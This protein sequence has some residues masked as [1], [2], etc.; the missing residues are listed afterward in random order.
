[1]GEFSK[2]AQSAE[3]DFK[4]TLCLPQTD[5]PLRADAAQNDPRMLLRWENEG[6]CETVMQQNAGALRFILHDGPPYANGH[7]HLGH[8]YN[9]VLKDIITKSYRMQGYHVPITPGWDC[10][11]LPIEQKVTSENPRLTGAALKKECRTY[12]LR[13]VETQKEEFKKLGVCMDWDNPYITMNPEYE[14]SILSAFASLV[15]QGFV[16]RKNKTI[17][18]CPT[19]A[20]A[21]AAAEIEYADRKDPSIFVLFPVAQE[22]DIPA[23]V[24][25]WTTTPWT[26]PLNQAVMVR[27][28]AMYV[29]VLVQGK[30][31]I[32]G[33][34]RFASVLDVE[35]FEQ[36]VVQEE[37]LGSSLVGMLLQHPL[38]E[39][40]V[41]VIGDMNVGVNEGSACVHCAPGC[42]PI[43][44]EV[45]IKQGL[46]IYSPISADGKYS[47]E[48][49]PREL[50]G[51]SVED[52]QI[53]VLRALKER[54]YLLRSGSVR[55][56]Y[57]HCWRCHNGLIFRATPQWFCSLQ[58][59][60]VKNRALTSIQQLSFFPEQGRAFL[61]ATVENRWEWCLSRQRNWGVPIPALIHK[62]NNTYWT[63]PELI[64]Y[65]A[66]E[67]A[68]AGIEFWDTVSLEA[69][70]QVGVLPAD[71]VLDEYRKETDILDV[72][73]DSGVS[74]YAVLQKQGNFPADLYLEGIDQHRGW[75]QSSLLTSII[76]H[77]A[78][79][80]KSI[81]THG[82]TVDGQGRK[83]S[84][85]LGNV[86][87]PDE[88][89]A[90][91]GTDG[92]RLWVASIGNEGDAVLS[93]TLIQNVI[94]VYRKIRNTSR[95]LLQN[96]YDY[97][98]KQDAV[99]L[100]K[101]SLID[102]YALFTLLEFQNN[103][104]DAYKRFD[105]TEVFRLV[106]EYCSS[107]VS[108]FYADITKDR[109]Y[110]DAAKGVSRRSAQTVIW[111]ILDTLTRLI[112]PICSLMAES[113]AD[114]YQGAGHASIHL[115]SFANLTDIQALFAQKNIEQ[116]RADWALLREIRSA[117]LKLIEEQ[118]AAG[119]IKHPLEVALYID[120][121]QFPKI[122]LLGN[123]QDVVQRLFQEL[124]VASQVVFEQSGDYV[125][126]PVAGFSARVEHATGSKCPRC[127]QWGVLGDKKVCARC[128][129][130][131]NS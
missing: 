21:L 42:G 50:V 113:V 95:F 3:H 54:G 15:G 18:W 93:K 52:G 35:G 89:I 110:C 63:S 128:A 55:H 81:M 112:A 99:A 77:T 49:E 69:L 107:E 28:D 30:N 23:F 130:V 47:E 108:A 76:L 39:R 82:F 59:N 4:E 103:V 115:Q 117:G 41:P 101:L 11:G 46:P 5:F 66:K 79:P 96:L 10:H 43:D 8:A 67:V 32:L 85:S 88:L 33:K 38:V 70:R 26:I 31:L 29:R 118:R 57:P 124:F 75:F 100:E 37:F 94:S 125:S 121:A 92:L 65:V 60:D 73:F 120:M 58:H 12:A 86:V 14:S 127:W 34:D 83:M 51:M 36:A 74:H 62:D 7:I 25:I 98:N 129:D 19:C 6:L 104:I 61:S 102:Q 68:I 44:Y 64:A 87:T 53:W 2:S 40:Q 114:Y 80:M 48:I 1:M 13:W 105:L 84:K 119:I 16:E 56:S 109:L 97:D 45:G 78:A 72:W 24:V 126:T 27:P 131:L 106:A 116:Y 123:D 17:P 9:K 91:V 22:I 20:T 111:R 71:L 90:Q 122:S